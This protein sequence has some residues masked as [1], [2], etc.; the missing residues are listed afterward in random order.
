MNNTKVSPKKIGLGFIL[1]R[2]TEQILEQ[3]MAKSEDQAFQDFI[4][5]HPNLQML[6]GEQ[7]TN[8]VPLDTSQAFDSNEEEDFISRDQGQDIF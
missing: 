1:A 3:D 4:R 8:F 2:F 7:T 6:T 5:Q